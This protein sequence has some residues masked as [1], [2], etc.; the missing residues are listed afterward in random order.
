MKRNTFVYFVKPVGQRGPVK[1]GVS[2]NPQR[3]LAEFQAAS[4]VALEMIGTM[5]GG[6]VTECRLHATFADLRLHGEWF[7]VDEH[8]ED[9]L[10]DVADG[11]HDGAYREKWYAPEF[12]SRMR[13][14]IVLPS[15]IFSYPLQGV[16]A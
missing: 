10:A 16:F 5:R 4:P 9:F 13:G 8:L 12:P 2:M 7:D 11:I 6:H 14:H 15:G 1:I 3:R